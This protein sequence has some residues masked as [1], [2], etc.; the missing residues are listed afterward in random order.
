[1]WGVLLFPTSTTGDLVPP[2]VTISIN[3]MTELVWICLLKTV[4]CRSN[5]QIWFLETFV[6]ACINDLEHIVVRRWLRCSNQPNQ[7][8][9]VE[10]A[11]ELFPCDGWCHSAKWKSSPT[12]TRP[13]LQIKFNH[14]VVIRHSVAGSR[15]TAT[16]NHLILAFLDLVG[17]LRLAEVIHIH[18]V[19]PLQQ[20]SSKYSCFSPHLNCLVKY[21]G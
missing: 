11:T 13:K 14:D 18:S 2:Y 21:S 4:F 6:E 16:G 5:E 3:D 19:Q 9:G 1:M 8:L 7:R 15:P 12:V 10:G 20:G 17:V